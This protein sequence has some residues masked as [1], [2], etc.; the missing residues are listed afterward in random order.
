M[1]RLQLL[2]HYSLKDPGSNPSCFYFIFEPNNDMFKKRVRI[3]MWVMD[4]NI[5]IEGERNLNCE[6]LL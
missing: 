4:L 1:R 3:S 2:L 5:P 6:V